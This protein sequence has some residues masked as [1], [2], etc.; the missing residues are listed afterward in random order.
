[1]IPR[2]DRRCGGGEDLSRQAS[3]QLRLSE[4]GA[5]DDPSAH[6]VQ[7]SR[8]PS[9]Y[10][11]CGESL[12]PKKLPKLENRIGFVPFSPL[13]RVSLPAQ[14]R[15]NQVAE[16]DSRYRAAIPAEDPANGKQAVVHLVG[17]IRGTEKQ[18]PEQIRARPGF[19]R[20]SPG[21]VPFPAKPSPTA[22]RKHRAPLVQLNSGRFWLKRK[23]SARSGGGAR[24]PEN[25]K[26]SIAKGIIRMAERRKRTCE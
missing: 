15:R 26:W 22:G 20:R 24:Y 16:T 17:K 6:A 10:S 18:T 1:L 9:D 2:A 25:S 21:C 23:A 19:W 11:L 14:S 13:E 4:E 3:Q 5:T 12:K 7:R 8:L